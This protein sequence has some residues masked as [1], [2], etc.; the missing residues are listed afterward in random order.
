M[1]S[2][3]FFILMFCAACSLRA[4]AVFALKTNPVCWEVSPQ[5]DSSLYSYWLL[6]SQDKEPVVVSYLNAAGEEV[7]GVNA[8]NISQGSCCCGQGGGGGAPDVNRIEIIQDS[9]FVIYSG[10]NEISRDTAASVI[11]PTYAI[12]VIQDSIITVLTDGVETSRDTIRYPAQEDRQLATHDQILTG[13]RLTDFGP[14][15]Y[16][17]DLRDA[18][19][20]Q[21]AHRVLTPDGK[22]YGW[23]ASDGLRELTWLTDRVSA[24]NFRKMLSYDDANNQVVFGGGSASSILRAT[25]LYIDANI[26]TDNTNTRA[27]SVDPVTNQVEYVDLPTGGSGSVQA[28]PTCTDT[29]TIS[30][31][32]PQLWQPLHRSGATLSPADTANLASF[33]IIDVVSATQVVICHEGAYETALPDGLYYTPTVAGPATTSAPSVQQFIFEVF[34]GVLYLD[35]Q[36]AVI[37]GGN[38]SAGSPSPSGAGMFSSAYQ[39]STWQVTQYRLSTQHT[40]LI[41]NNGGFLLRDQSGTAFNNELLLTINAA[42][43][44]SSP[45]VVALGSGVGMPAVIV[46]GSTTPNAGRIL[47]GYGASQYNMPVQRPTDVGLAP[48]SYLPVVDETGA[49]VNSGW[50][51]APN[52]SDAGFG[53]ATTDGNGQITITHN[54]GVVPTILEAWGEGTARTYAQPI[55]AT[56]LTSTQMMIQ[57]FGTGGTALTNT[58]VSFG[59]RVTE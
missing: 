18:A 51:R 32:T 33:V 9:I 34:N 35:V 12:T 5:V 41:E 49:L 4:Q 47:L 1:R 52:P 36:D 15:P 54:L 3:C 6:S 25:D 45:P 53:T 19:I 8:A 11:V 22:T 17:W 44:V 29:V 43:G 42:D 7:V 13:S 30:G 59:W 26:P 58:S 16:T 21:M 14:Y 46:D 2:I 31:F 38:G 55:R 40:G 39:D 20:D 50:Q 27:I 57:F 28:V 10:N 48:N 23:Y 24:F 56:G 37:S